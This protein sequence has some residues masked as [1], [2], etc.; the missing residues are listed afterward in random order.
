METNA[1][2]RAEEKERKA[3]HRQVYHYRQTEYEINEYVF[4]TIPM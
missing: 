2:R 3:Y 4:I 1:R